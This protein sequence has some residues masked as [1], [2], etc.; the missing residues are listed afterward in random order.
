VTA[1]PSVEDRA[2]R[3][4]RALEEALEERNRLWEELQ[5]R[6]SQE[7]DLAYWRGRAQDIERSRWWR[8]GRP[9]RLARCALQDPAVAF[10]ALARRL[11]PTRD[12]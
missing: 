4:E 10:E 8:A 11:R 1:E 2:E 5:R 9:L 7:E 3:A 6:K 12:R